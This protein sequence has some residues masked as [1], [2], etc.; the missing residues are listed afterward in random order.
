MIFG[1]GIALMPAVDFHH[2]NEYPETPGE[3]ARAYTVESF[4][5]RIIK[6]SGFACQLP[7]MSGFVE[8]ADPNYIAP[9]FFKLTKG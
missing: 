6:P 2:L 5:E 9:M 3:K 8:V 4:F 7:D 1:P